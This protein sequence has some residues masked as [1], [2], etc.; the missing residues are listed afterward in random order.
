M[1]GEEGTGGGGGEGG[2]GR[3]VGVGA[4][5]RAEE[6]LDMDRHGGGGEAARTSVYP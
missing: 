6:G 4:G 3:E 1:R 2:T 5:R